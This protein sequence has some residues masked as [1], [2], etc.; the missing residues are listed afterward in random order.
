MFYPGD[1][2]NFI[3]NIPSPGVGVTSVTSAPLI[4]ILD[5]LNPGSP[6]VSGAAMTLVTGTSFVYYYSFTIPNASPKDYIAIYSYASK[7]VQS[8]GTA[9]A[10]VWSTG[11]ASYTFPLPLPATCV[12]GALLTTSGF[13][14]GSG[15]GNF[16]VTNAPI[17]TVNPSTGVVTVAVVGSA[18]VVGTLGTGSVSVVTTVSNQLVTVKDELHVGDSYVTGPVALN[19]TVAQ[20]STVAKDATVMKSS[21]YVA[22]QNDPTVQ[23][24]AAQ[25]NT[26]NNNTA[27]TSTLLGTLA[28]G[29]LSGLIQDIYD[30][31]FGAWRI[32]NTVSPPVLYISRINGTPIASFTLQQTVSATQ[33]IV[34]TSPPESSV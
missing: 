12:A 22:P 5:I 9:T 20:N 3:L 6:I 25:T 28:A 13:T 7:N 32:D 15:T 23:T 11:I 26:I 8:L 33:R 24:I 30:Y 16:N 27:A 14:T 4:T 19:A 1:T 21:Q 10:A 18:L 2:Y 17:L 31:S 34:I 29:T